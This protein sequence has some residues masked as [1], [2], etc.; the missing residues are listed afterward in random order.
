MNNAKRLLVI[1]PMLA[2]LFG[3]KKKTDDDKNLTTNKTTKKVV[4]TKKNNQTNN[5]TAKK[6]TKKNIDGKVHYEFVDYDGTVLLANDVTKGTTISQSII[7]NPSRSSEGNYF[8]YF[9]GW[10]KEVNRTINDDVTYKAQYEKL[11]IPYEVSGNKAYFGFYPQTLVTDESLKSTLNSSAKLP[12]T[13]TNW[14]SYNYYEDNS[15]SDYMWYIDID[16]NGDS[17]SDYRGVYFTKYRPKKVTNQATPGNSYVDDYDYVLDEVYWFKYEKVEWTILKNDSESM[18][19]LADLVLDSRDFYPEH[20]NT[21][22]SHNGAEGYVNTYK[23]SEVRKWLNNEFYNTIFNDTEQKII[24]LSDFTT[25]E[26][27][28]SGSSKSSTSKDYVYLLSDSELNEYIP[29]A[30]SRLTHTTDY[31]KVQGVE[32]NV[33]CLRTPSSGS[34]SLSSTAISIQYVDYTGN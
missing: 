9:T 19:M 33:W 25:R 32:E 18:L 14:I 11:V 10:D 22:F 6:T 26:Y 8:Y 16:T 24:E 2:L 31:A 17:R 29:T 27:T 30:T 3:C 21:P 13:N 23:L 5:T 20:T 7:P 12:Q 28:Q 1:L 4:T 34:P 15:K